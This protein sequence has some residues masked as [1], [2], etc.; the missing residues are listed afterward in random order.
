[1][2]R[3][4]AFQG[5]PAEA[6]LRRTPLRGGKGLKRGPWNVHASG[7]CLQ[8]TGQP[9]QALRSAKRSPGLKAGGS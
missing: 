7:R 6:R 8:Q 3:K 9:R 4:P 5:F 2:P 1:M